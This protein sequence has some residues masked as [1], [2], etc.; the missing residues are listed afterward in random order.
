MHC[1]ISFILF[2]DVN[3]AVLS[4]ATLP[5]NGSTIT[6]NAT[7]S[8]PGYS[9]FNENITIG[10]GYR[11]CLD[12]LT[13]NQQLVP[14][15]NPIEDTDISTCGPRLPSEV[16][17]RFGDGAWLFGAGSYIQFTSQQFESPQLLEFEF[18]TFDASGVLLFYPLSEDQY[19]FL[20]LLEGRLAADYNPSPLNF[21]H[22]ETEV[23]FNS[24]LWY[25]VSALITDQS[26]TVSINDTLTLMRNSS[27]VEEVDF[28]PAGALL[29]GGIPAFYSPYA[30]SVPIT[31]SI[32]GCMRN[33]T[34]GGIPLN[35]QEGV[36]NRVDF[37][38]CPQIVTSGVRFMGTGRVEFLLT[39][40]QLQ[41]FDITF[42]FRTTQ[43][44]A[45][46]FSFGEF[47]VSIFHTKLRVDIPGGLTL[48]SDELGLNDNI[49]HTGS[50]QLS[51]LENIL[52]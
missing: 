35:M 22:L 34:F 23:A 32:A 18:R 45:L 9:I 11:G 1:D 30:E 46:L 48:I 29:F 10:G 12:R 6:V 25:R 51:S 49:Q 50:V 26:V 17:R 16:A 24:G 2:R 3:K 21:L 13:V 47:S 28:K 7:T 15:L 36:S 40:Q 33:L 42:A 5:E 52:M 4:L 38:G 41:N 14:L 37:G 27:T 43:L 19:L 39:S 31:S 20:Y 8:S 44:V